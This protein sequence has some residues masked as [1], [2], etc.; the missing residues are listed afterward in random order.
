MLTA[1]E[2]NHSPIQPAAEYAVAESQ[3]DWR[4]IVCQHHAIRHAPRAPT[5]L[6][7]P[8]LQSLSMQTNCQAS[9][10]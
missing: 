6:A 5:S 4:A 7:K 10:D 8:A 3:C 1:N 9:F 2:T